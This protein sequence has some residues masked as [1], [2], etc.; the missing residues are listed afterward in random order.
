MSGLRNCVVFGRI[1]MKIPLLHIGRKYFML[2]P[3]KTDRS[4]R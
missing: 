4:V 1:E 2:N 3:L